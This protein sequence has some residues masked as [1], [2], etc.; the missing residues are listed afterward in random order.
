MKTILIVDD[1]QSELELMAKYLTQAGYLIIKASDGEAYIRFQLTLEMTALLPMKQV[2]ESLVVEAVKITTLPSMP[3]S[4][5]GMMSSRNRVFCVFDLAQIL[6]L[7]TPL[8]SPRQYHVIVSQSDT[9]QSTYLGLAVNRLQGM[10]RLNSN[11][12]ESSSE[13]LP[14]H[15]LPY[16][17]GVV[18]EQDLKIPVLELSLILEA[19]KKIN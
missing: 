11:K 4:V 1:L 6:T 5:I 3:K 8:I 13:N 17:S 9:E 14:S 10:I 18:Q 2:Q 19:L 15:L 16:L 7:S 12:I